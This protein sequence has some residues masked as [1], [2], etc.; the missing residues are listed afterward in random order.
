MD[1]ITAEQFTAR[2][3]SAPVQDDLERCN[4]EKAGQMGH[5]QCGW[6]AEFQLP[7]FIVG[8]TPEQREYFRNNLLA[9]FPRVQP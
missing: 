8:H 9:T 4:C 5:W 1:K 6:D 2:V 7:V 3:G